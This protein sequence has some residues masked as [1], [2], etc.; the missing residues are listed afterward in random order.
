LI[1][2]RTLASNRSSFSRRL[3]LLLVVVCLGAAPVV[4]IPLEEYHDNL[5]HILEDLESLLQKEENEADADYESRF[6]ETIETMREELP[7]TQSV[8]LDKE[9]WNAD[10]SWF[11]TRLDELQRAAPEERSAR[12]SKIIESLRALDERVNELESAEEVAYDKNAANERLKG[13]LARDE[14]AGASR[15]ENAF[16]RL[17]LDFIRWLQK[18][19]PDLGPVEPGRGSFITQIVQFVVIGV[20]L[21]IIAYVIRSLFIRFRRPGAKKIRKKREP[22]IVLGERLEPEETSSDLLSEAEALARSGDLRGAIRKGYIALLVELGDRKL[23]S[24]AQYKTNRDYLRSVSSHPQ[25]HSR[26]K[27]LTDSFERHWYGFAQV[28]PT[29]WQDFR[30]GYREALQTG[31]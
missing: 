25:L 14:Y 20:T 15:G 12:I 18:L 16:N 8:E 28:T 10:N 31:N 22:R 4:A 27:G 23:L 21:L 11:H 2:L 9:T 6:T 13:I 29:D 26:M 17:L 1:A 19:L 3:L 24:L 5:E 7:K 30:T